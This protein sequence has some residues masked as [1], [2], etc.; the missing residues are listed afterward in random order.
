MF[1]NKVLSVFYNSNENNNLTKIEIP[2]SINI[3]TD[4]DIKSFNK[5]KSL[6]KMDT[7]TMT[8]LSN[9]LKQQERKWVIKTQDFNLISDIY[10][11]T[12]SDACKYIHD[13][14]LDNMS[15]DLDIYNYEFECVCI[16]INSN[17]I[18]FESLDNVKEYV[19]FSEDSNKNSNINDID[20][21]IYKI[22]K[23]K[24]NIFSVFTKQLNE[25]YLIMPIDLY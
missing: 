12:K 1:Y 14:I 8:S 16:D 4:D 17:I 22:M 24:N 19:S 10:F 13:I 18:K 11:N 5:T 3:I 20:I 25:C 21:V 2:P 15:Y 9:E 7:Q 6:Q 23:R